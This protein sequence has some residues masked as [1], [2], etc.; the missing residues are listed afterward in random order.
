MKD[1]HKGTV[2]LIAS[3]WPDPITNPIAYDEWCEA[4]ACQRCDGTGVIED[5]IDEISEELYVRACLSCGGL[6]FLAVEKEQ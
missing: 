2:V 5:D 4:H 1:Q 3:K 6:G